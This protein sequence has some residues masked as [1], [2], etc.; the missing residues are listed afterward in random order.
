MKKPDRSHGAS[1]CVRSDRFPLRSLNPGVLAERPNQ[2][3]LVYS[4]TKIIDE[5][6]LCE[7][8]EILPPV[9]DGRSIDF[10]DVFEDSG[11]QFIEG[12]DSD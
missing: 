3:S 2:R 8:L 11:F 12:L 9:Y 6:I 4:F 10:V 7:C 5:S 1:G